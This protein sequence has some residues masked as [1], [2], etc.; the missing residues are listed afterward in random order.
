MS[1]THQEG[2]EPSD[3]VRRH[4]HSGRVQGN[5]QKRTVFIIRRRPEATHN[6]VFNAFEFERAERVE[7]LD[8]YLDRSPS[9]AGRFP[10]AVHDTLS[11]ARRSVFVSA[12]VDGRAKEI[13]VR[14]NVKTTGRVTAH[15]RSET[16]T[17]EFRPN[18]H[19]PTRTHISRRRNER[20]FQPFPQMY[21]GKVENCRSENE[22]HQRHYVRRTGQVSVRVVI[23]TGKGRHGGLSKTRRV[24]ILRRQFGIVS[25]HIEILRTHLGGLHG[26]WTNDTS[27]IPHKNVELL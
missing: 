10:S 23:C 8:L 7:Y 1:S 17:Y 4:D 18:V 16:D 9:G 26:L 5:Q 12:R 15:A 11:R 24:Q 19:V 13:H 6:V 20:L 14:T 21:L 25:A 2:R 22:I 27:R 3:R